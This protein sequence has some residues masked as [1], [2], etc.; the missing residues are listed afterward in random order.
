MNGWTNLVTS[1]IPTSSSHFMRL[2][3]SSKKEHQESEEGGLKE[4][5][6]RGLCILMT[7]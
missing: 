4:H 5:K 3:S 6:V 2:D 7:S 1:R